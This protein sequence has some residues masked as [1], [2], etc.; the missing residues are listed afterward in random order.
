VVERGPDRLLLRAHPP[1][2]AVVKVLARGAVVMIRVHEPSLEDLVR[3]VAREE[4]P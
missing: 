3:S 1:L 4:V 2:D